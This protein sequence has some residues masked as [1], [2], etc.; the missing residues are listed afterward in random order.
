MVK[1]YL[2]EMDNG[3]M[4]EDYQ[5]WIKAAFTTHRKASQWLINSGYVP[6]ATHDI[7]GNIIVEFYKDLKN[8][9]ILEI[10]LVE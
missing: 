10:E 2:V 3:E 8:A 6:Y 9:R 4:Y 5:A 1:V 7:A